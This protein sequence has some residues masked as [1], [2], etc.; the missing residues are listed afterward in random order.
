LNW[1]IGGLWVAYVRQ[2][3]FDN[4]SAYV[5]TQIQHTASAPQSAPSSTMPPAAP[6]GRLTVRPSGATSPGE[7]GARDTRFAL[8]A[9]NSIAQLT[10]GFSLDGEAPATLAV[11]DVVGR[12]VM[13]RQVVSTGPGWRTVQFEGLP[14]GVYG[15][16]LRQGGR[17]LSCRAVVVH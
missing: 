7:L 5:L 9:L 4:S 14:S 10:V 2:P 6:R 1:G 16:R 15:V 12:Q 8:R 3:A 17:S 13:Q 11:Y